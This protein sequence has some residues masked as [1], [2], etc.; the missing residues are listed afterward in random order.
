MW[1]PARQLSFQPSELE[2]LDMKRL[3]IACNLTAALVSLGLLTTPPVALADDFVFGGDRFASG[4]SADLTEPALR[5]AFVSGFTA[6][7]DEAVSGDAHLAGFN[8]DLDENVRGDAY[9]AGFNVTID[10][11]VGDD[12][13]A[14][15][16]S[17]SVDKGVNVGGNAR[18]AGATVTM[19]GS[20]AG[21]LAIAAKNIELDG[22]VTGDVSLVSQNIEFGKD[23]VINGTLSYSAPER[24]DI[25]ENVVAADRVQYT[26]L[27][28]SERALGMRQMREMAQDAFWPS[29]A[30]AIFGALI[31]FVF[32]LVVAAICLASAP[33]LTEMLR[34]NTVEKPWSSLIFGGFGMALLIGLVPVTAMTIIGIPLVPFA[35]LAIAAAWVLGYLLGVYV[36]TWRLVGAFRDLPD[37]LSGRLILIGFGIVVL[38]LLNF[39]P[40]FGW[41]INV[42]VVLAGLGG[43]TAMLMRR[44][45]EWRGPEL[46]PNVTVHAPSSAVEEPEKPADET[47]ENGKQ[48]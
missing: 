32:L 39:V 15:G 10:A 16:M 12:L 31:G 44:L 41:L 18:L 5:D 42:I 23:A 47:V 38:A 37:S 45:I 8:V 28:I 48:T 43:L 13:S 36:V 6:S 27:S 25:P 17:V 2:C 19:E 7:L 3:S 29:V 26:Q 21:S 1:V 33:L 24:I 11:D 14:S 22:A 34:I 35:L 30:S 40:F 20:I 46:S 4:S 9:T